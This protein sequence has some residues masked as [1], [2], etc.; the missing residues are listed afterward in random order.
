MQLAMTRFRFEALSRLGQ[1][2]LP[3]DRCRRGSRKS[4]WQGLL[5]VFC[6]VSGVHAQLTAY[7]S[8]RK[9]DVGDTSETMCCKDCQHKLKSG[10]LL[11]PYWDI[12]ADDW[13]FIQDSFMREA[14][15]R[16]VKENEGTSEERL[17]AD[18]QEAL[19][20][21]ELSLSQRHA[22]P[23]LLEALEASEAAASSG[24]AD[25]CSCAAQCLLHEAEA[26]RYDYEA[27]LLA[28]IEESLESAAASDDLCS[29]A[30]AY[31][32]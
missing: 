29:R 32:T 19:L 10:G 25:S 9:D 16:S 18:L 6:G 5:C 24:S 15:D 21:S 26:K 17:A 31:E 13:E 1:Q 30:A 22:D 23:E 28:A 11:K 2:R 27:A 8:R 20:L 12:D 14:I 7:Y 4:A 3:R